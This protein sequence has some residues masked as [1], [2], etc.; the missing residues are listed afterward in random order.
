MIE[1]INNLSSKI[2]A[3]VERKTTIVLGGNL[4]N[5]YKKTNDK[6]KVDFITQNLEEILK[7]LSLK[8]KKIN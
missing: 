8:Y 3:I 6:L 1:K 5:T 7:Q 2:S 4:V